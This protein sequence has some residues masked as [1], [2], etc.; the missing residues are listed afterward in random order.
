MMKLFDPKHR[1]S[2]FLGLLTGILFLLIGAAALHWSWNMIGHELLGA[3][4][5][6]F[7]HGLAV[8]VALLVLATPFRIGTCRLSCDHQGN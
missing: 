8:M 2:I 4:R 7:R 3:P 1:R 5:I 6:E